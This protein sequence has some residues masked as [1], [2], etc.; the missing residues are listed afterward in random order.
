VGEGPEKKNDKGKKMQKVVWVATRTW[1]K[2][3]LDQSGWN[4]HSTLYSR[5]QLGEAAEGKKKK[6]RDLVGQD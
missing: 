3:G 1:G 4:Q 2:R 5:G 6:K